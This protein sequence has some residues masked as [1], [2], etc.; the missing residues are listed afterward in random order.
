MNYWMNDIINIKEFYNR[1]ATIISYTRA[2]FNYM[3]MM[4]NFFA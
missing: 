2:I 1:P 3:V 4:I